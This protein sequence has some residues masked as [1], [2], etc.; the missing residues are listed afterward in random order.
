MRR[1]LSGWTVA[2]ATSLGPALAVVVILTSPP[3]AEFADCAAAGFL[4]GVDDRMVGVAL[5]CDEAVRFTIE[6]PG[7]TRQVR[8]VY[9][10]SDLSPGLLGFVADIR[11]GIETAAAMLRAIGE[12]DTADITIWASALASPEDDIGVT[13]ATALP[14]GAIG[15]ECVISLYSG[16]DSA[17][18]AAHEFF[19][20]VQYATVGTKSLSRESTWWVEGSAEWFASSVF[21]GGNASDADVATFDSISVDVS[22]TAMVQ[23]S[24]VFFFWLDENFGY[25]TRLVG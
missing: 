19:H 12:G 14:L 4:G 23:E 24:V 10:T 3:R 2:L 11:R 8:I 13:G 5:P 25:R 6:T 20:C 17:Y 7:G 22:L 1:I 21:P 16:G 9:S 18:V 15:S